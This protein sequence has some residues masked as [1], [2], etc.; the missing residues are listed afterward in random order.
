MKKKNR[1]HD[2]CVHITTP[3][4]FNSFN[5]MNTAPH[6]VSAFCGSITGTFVLAGFLYRVGVSRSMMSQMLPIVPLPELL[7]LK[8]G[9]FEV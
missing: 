2:S 6:G 1:V 9:A 7:L 8:A 5:Q 4:P 3:G